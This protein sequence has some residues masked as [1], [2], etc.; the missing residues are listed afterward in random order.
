MPNHVTNILEFKSTPARVRTLLREIMYDDGD[1]GSFDFEKVI[2]KPESLNVTSGGSQDT[3]IDVYMSAINPDNEDLGID[4]VSKTEYNRIKSLIAESDRMFVRKI[5]DHMTHEEVLKKSEEYFN[6]PTSPFDEKNIDDN[7]LFNYG[8]IVVEN[9]LMYGCKDW[10]SWCCKFWGTKW[11]SYDSCPVDP[12]DTSISFNTAWAAP[13]P[14]IE[15]LAEM[16]PDVIITH[17]WAD[18]DWGNNTGSCVYNDPDIGVMEPNY[19]DGHEAL[20]FAA[21]ILGYDMDNYY[22]DH[23]LCLDIENEMPLSFTEDDKKEWEKAGFNFA[24]IPEVKKDAEGQYDISKFTF[25]QK[26]AMIDEMVRCGIDAYEFF[27]S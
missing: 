18:E 27:Y 6:R 4:K 25:D 11:N 17:K 16:Y 12:D 20:V 1:I 3:A 21:E 26:K 24:K 2:P 13:H 5:N 15:K 23:G 9:V 22:T 14:V 8:K 19:L 10:Y 7:N